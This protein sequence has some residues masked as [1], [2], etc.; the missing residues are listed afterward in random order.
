MYYKHLNNVKHLKAEAKGLL[1]RL[2][3]IMNTLKCHK[4]RTMTIDKK[5]NCRL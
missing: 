5:I 2:L 1:A 4:E 3:V